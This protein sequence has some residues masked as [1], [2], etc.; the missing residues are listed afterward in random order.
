MSAVDV[1]LSKS[2]EEFGAFHDLRY[3]N[4]NEGGNSN[5]SMLEITNHGG[6]DIFVEGCFLEQDPHT[7]K[8]NRT[9]YDLTSGRGLDGIRIHIT[10]GIENS[11]FLQMLRLILEAEKMV[12]IVKP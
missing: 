4:D 8:W 10:G 6:N 1:T 12:D 11:E 2:G 3:T 7:K 9:W 5:A